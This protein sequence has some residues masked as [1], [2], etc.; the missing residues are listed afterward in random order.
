MTSSD[1]YIG[2]CPNDYD[3]E[4]CYQLTHLCGGSE[5]SIVVF[6]F[7]ILVEVASFSKDKV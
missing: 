3:D 1:G 4:K 5:A 6:F 7:D 2:S